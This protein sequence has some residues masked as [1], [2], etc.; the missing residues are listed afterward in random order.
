MDTA[1]EFNS[2]T[3]IEYC[4]TFGIEVEHLVAHIYTKNGLAESMIEH[5]QIVS[6]TLLI[7]I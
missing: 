2:K 7:E 6:H 1:G 3:F 5:V 4:T